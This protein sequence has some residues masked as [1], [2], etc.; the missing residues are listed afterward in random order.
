MPVKCML[1]ME[2]FGVNLKMEGNG[3]TGSVRELHPLLAFT[4]AIEFTYMLCYAGVFIAIFCN[5]NRI[6]T[7]WMLNDME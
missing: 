1:W 3:F 7:I 2:F 6:S 4:R 5:L